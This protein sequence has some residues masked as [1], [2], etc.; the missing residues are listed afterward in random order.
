MFKLR[1]AIWLGRRVLIVTTTAGMLAWPQ[2]FAGS[3]L[4]GAANSVDSSSITT[5]HDSVDLDAH[6]HYQS[7]ADRANDALLITEVKSAIAEDGVA[8]DSVI[9]V[10]CDH[11]KIL[12]SGVMGS[13]EEARRA[14]EIAAGAQGVVGVK[15]RL[16]WH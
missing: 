9:V 6:H 8:E 10:D 12:L 13:A 16:T 5:E 1:S 3:A 15:N 11:G 4:A 2:L 7:P 14:G